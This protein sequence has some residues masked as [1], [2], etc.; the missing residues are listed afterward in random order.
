MAYAGPGTP[1]TDPTFENNG[2]AGWKCQFVVRALAGA[3]TVPAPVYI[4]SGTDAAPVTTRKK[5]GVNGS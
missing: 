5:Y 2:T 3:P 4:T 1:V